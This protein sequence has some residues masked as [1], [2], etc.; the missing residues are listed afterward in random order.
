MKTFKLISLDVLEK[1]GDELI[2]RPIPL[3][4][5]LIINRED[6]DNHWL[7][8]AYM[9]DN[10][11]EYFQQKKNENREHV[12]QVKISKETNEPATM[13][14]KIVGLNNIGNAIN[15]LFIGTLVNRRQDKV[16]EMLQELIQEGYQ[17]EE[18][19]RLFKKKNKI[20]EISSN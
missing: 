10:Q 16:E 13:M 17:G 7:I 19:L 18:L 15:V 1:N 3:N 2:N 4:D 8:E 12:L 5:G 20:V 6:D 9:D 14:A 11:K